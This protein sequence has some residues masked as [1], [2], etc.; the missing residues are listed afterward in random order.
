MATAAEGEGM[1]WYRRA[2]LFSAGLAIYYS[3]G[4]R[5]CS[6]I[7]CHCRCN[8]L[9]LPS[10]GIRKSWCVRRTRSRGKARDDVSDRRVR[11]HCVT[12][13]GWQRGES[14][15]CCRNVREWRPRFSARQSIPWLHL[16]CHIWR[17]S[18]GR[19]SGASGSRGISRLAFCSLQR[20]RRSGLRPRRV[21]RRGE[22]GDASLEKRPMVVAHENTIH[23]TRPIQI[24][25]MS[26]PGRLCV[27]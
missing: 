12:E 11:A 5:S 22:S 8:I 27:A 13:E 7:L 10:R 15:I 21:R 17:C 3:V 9:G 1:G 19:S 4:T 2:R 14:C 25:N 24:P 16:R 20:S 6:W 23:G 26:T 18:S